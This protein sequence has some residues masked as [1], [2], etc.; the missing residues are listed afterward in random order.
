MIIRDKYPIEAD[1]GRAGKTRFT[2]GG[3][4]FVTEG[5]GL[6]GKGCYFFVTRRAEEFRIFSAAETGE[7]KQD[8]KRE[9]S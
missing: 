5:T 8:I 6:S 2:M 4:M 3:D 7:W 1:T 9:L